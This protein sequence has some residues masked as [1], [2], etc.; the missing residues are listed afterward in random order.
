ME[1]RGGEIK[2]AA[3]RRVKDRQTDRRDDPAV[4]RSARH[5]SF[6]SCPSCVQVEP[7]SSLFRCESVE[8]LDSGK[9]WK[10][11]PGRVGSGNAVA[12]FR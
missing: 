11:K 4:D 6:C 9:R 5:K 2:V 8:F 12:L 10:P 1:G 7:P 3:G